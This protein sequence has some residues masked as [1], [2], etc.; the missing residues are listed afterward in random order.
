ME[1]LDLVIIIPVRKVF[2][3]KILLEL[4][5]LQ[6]PFTDLIYLLEVFPPNGFPSIQIEYGNSCL[7]VSWIILH[8]K[9]LIDPK[10][11]RFSFLSHLYLTI[12]SR[13]FRFPKFISR[14]IPMVPSSF[15]M[16]RWTCI[17]TGYFRIR[18]ST[19]SPSSS[20][21]AA[22]TAFWSWCTS[23]KIYLFL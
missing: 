15:L 9:V 4:F 16:R 2:L 21:S 14:A 18:W 3:P 11:P 12:N 22:L 23:S 1:L 17:P 5:P 13:R 8:L 7:H 6:F 10:K 19:G 20:P